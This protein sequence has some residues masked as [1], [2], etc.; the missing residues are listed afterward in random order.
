MVAAP[1][2]GDVREEG[3]VAIGD[4][5]KLVSV[6]AIAV[7]AADPEVLEVGRMVLGIGIVARV[8]PAFFHLRAGPDMFL[9]PG[10]VGCPADEVAVVDAV[11]GSRLLDAFVGIA[12]DFGIATIGD[13]GHRRD[14]GREVFL[15]LSIAFLEVDAGIDS[16]AL[17]SS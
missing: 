11:E 6:L 4:V 14:E 10:A 9:V 3:N 13:A 1:V 2:G 12:H 8:D 17:F 15:E 16:S 7:L 5:V